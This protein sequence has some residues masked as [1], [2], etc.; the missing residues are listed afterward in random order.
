MHCHNKRMA[1]YSCLTPEEKSFC[2]GS[3]SPNTYTD[4]IRTYLSSFL[5]TLNS[6]FKKWLDFA[7]KVKD[8]PGL[9]GHCNN[10]KGWLKFL[11]LI[12][13]DYFGFNR[14]QFYKRKEVHRSFVE[15]SDLFKSVRI[16]I[17]K[18]RSLSRRPKP[19]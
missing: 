1:E 11:P 7:I 16:K 17:N 5:H 19:K 13:L 3:L 4:V 10:H 15:Y 12:W 8:T 6:V 2:H 18:V 9:Q 14:C